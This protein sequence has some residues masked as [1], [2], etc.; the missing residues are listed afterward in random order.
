M[1]VS[2]DNACYVTFKILIENLRLHQLYY[3]YEYE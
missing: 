1:L 2:K 3:E